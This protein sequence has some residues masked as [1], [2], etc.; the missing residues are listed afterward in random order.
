MFVGCLCNCSLTRMI[1]VRQ[2]L[3]SVVSRALVILFV[4]GCSFGLSA[5]QSDAMIVPDLLTSA[6]QFNGQDVDVNGAYLGRSGTTL[7]ALGV[8]TQDNGLDAQPLGDLIWLEGFPEEQLKDRL[9][10]PGDAIYGFVNIKGRF[11]T[12]GSYGPDSTYKHR[13]QVKAATPIEQV[14]RNEVRVPDGDLGEG[15]VSLRT[16]TADPAAYNGQQVTTRGYYF[17]NG[18]IY[19]LAEGVSAEVDGSNP[20]PIGKQVWME[21]F[22]PDVSGQLKV[23]PGNPPAYVWGL[24]EVTGQ[25]QSGGAFGKDGAYTEFLQ[26]DPNAPNAAKAIE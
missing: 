18:V 20:Q 17:W 2:Q 16:L 5:C 13:I 25:F 7:L 10:Q 22:P 8:S 1:L 15:K 24:V 4:M 11:E 9:H 6:A 26:L 21:G 14:R 23:G 19:V 3:M 12:G